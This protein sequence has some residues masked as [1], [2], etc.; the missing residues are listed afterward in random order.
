MQI[1]FLVKVFLIF[2]YKALKICSKFPVHESYASGIFSRKKP[3]GFPWGFPTHGQDFPQGKERK[4]LGD[5]LQ[6]QLQDKTL[7]L[8]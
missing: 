5:F 6:V 3:P 2:R 8:C 4:D 1:F 7:V